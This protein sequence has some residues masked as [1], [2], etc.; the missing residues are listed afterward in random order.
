MALTKMG[1]W[2]DS[3]RTG[4]ADWIVIWE[5]WIKLQDIIEGYKLA[6]SLDQK[7]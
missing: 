6:K 3:K 1:R 2:Y 5:G 4:R 7:I